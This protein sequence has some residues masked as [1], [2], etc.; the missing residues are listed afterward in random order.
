MKREFKLS[1]F[2]IGGAFGWLA[3]IINTELLLVPSI[4]MQLS[5]DDYGYIL[6]TILGAILIAPVVEETMKISGVV[7]LKTQENIVVDVK[8]WIELGLLS[9]LGFSVLENITYFM[10]FVSST[11]VLTALELLAVRFMMSTPV[12]LTTTTIA[13]YGIGNYDIS[14]KK[15]YIIWLFVA[16]LIHAS[17]NLSVMIIEGVV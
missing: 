11:D 16:M 9:A 13:A 8:K 4:G 15:N 6:I 3:G 12:H 7:F 1:M 17:F 5:H 14:G 2:V 10:G